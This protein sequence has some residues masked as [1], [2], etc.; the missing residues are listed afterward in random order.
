M[1][2][3]DASLSRRVSE[4][5]TAVILDRHPLWHEAIGQI[6]AATGIRSVGSTTSPAEMLG[7]VETL[8][9]DLLVAEPSAGRPS[10]SE[11]ASLRRARELHPDL[12]IVVVSA[13]DDREDVAAA[14]DAGAAAYV[15]K[16]A[17]PA[18]I[19]TAIRQCFNPSIFLRSA[20]TAVAPARE[21]TVAPVR[22]LAMARPAVATAE[23]CGLTRRELEILRLVGEGHT[24]RQ[25]AGMLWVT[26]QT[27][28][29]H[30]SNIYRKL[31]VSNRTEAAR[32]A[33]RQG[34][35]IGNDGPA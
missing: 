18:D 11:V 3:M 29:F 23:T 22:E 1:G 30:L 19:A 14:F 20:E 27:V 32:W 5:S 26:E 31:Q 35:L 21:L 7:L 12:R 16:T 28:K 4:A 13:S 6:L 9:P 2:E 17:E 25:L 24:N 15:L 8:R 33:Q 10:S 34:L